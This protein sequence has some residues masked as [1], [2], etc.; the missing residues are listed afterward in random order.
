VDCINNSENNLVR[1]NKN[2]IRIGKLG[3]QISLWKVLEVTR[4]LPTGS[5]PMWRQKFLRNG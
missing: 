1:T 5:R 2:Q 3:I 4:D